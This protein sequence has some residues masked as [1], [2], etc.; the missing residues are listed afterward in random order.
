MEQSILTP[1]QRVV[2]E[3][4]AGNADIASQFYLTGGTALAE[5]Y[6]RHRYSDDLDFFS[7]VKDFP[8]ILIERFAGDIKTAF[9]IESVEY[10]RLHDRRIFFFLLQDNEELKMEF[11]LYPF[12]QINKPERKHGIAVDSLQDI[13][14]NKIMAMMDRI[15]SKDFVD[16]YF[17]LEEKGIHLDEILAC[18]KQKFNITIDPITIGSEFAKV[19]HINLLPRMI[20]SLTIEQL[21]IF[22]TE[23]A[24]ALKPKIFE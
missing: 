11:T 5:Y 4:V 20:K 16:L 8:Q 23:R 17:I 21:K 9:H 24:A 18:V 10:R 3:C 22:F 6:L 7:S 19:R 13:A 15:E 12:R 2:L 1:S 14:A